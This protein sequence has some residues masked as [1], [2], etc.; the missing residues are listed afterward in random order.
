MS[1]SN[2]MKTPEQRQF[3]ITIDYQYIKEQKS[4]NPDA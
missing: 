1:M 2:S 4:G 3:Y